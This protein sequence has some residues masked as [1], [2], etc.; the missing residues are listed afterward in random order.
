MFDDKAFGEEID[1]DGLPKYSPDRKNVTAY[2]MFKMGMT[3]RMPDPEETHTPFFRTPSY[4]RE[5]AEKERQDWDVLLDVPA[6]PKMPKLPDTVSG[7]SPVPP[8][9]VE[10]DIPDPQG[11]TRSGSGGASSSGESAFQ[12]IFGK[13][14]DAYVNE[15]FGEKRLADPSFG[16]FPLPDG[17]PAGGSGEAV[18]PE[19]G[20]EAY[21]NQLA[22]GSVSFRD[23]GY[24]FQPDRL[25]A[26]FPVEA[27]GRRHVPGNAV[28]DGARRAVLRG[29][30]LTGR[31]GWHEGLEVSPVP[32]KARGVMQGE[33]GAVRLTG[34]GPVQ[35]GFVKASAGRAGARGSVKELAA[36]SAGK[37]PRKSQ[38]AGSAFRPVFAK[39]N[40]SNPG[41]Q[42]MEIAIVTQEHLP[43]PDG[44]R[45]VS[46]EMSRDMNSELTR[47]NRGYA[48]G[49]N[50]TALSRLEGGS[51]PYANLPIARK[52][53]DQERRERDEALEKG[54]QPPVRKW[55]N[56]SGATIGSGFDLGQTSLDEMRRFGLPESLVQKCAPYVGK[57]R[58]DAEDML[59][60]RPLV[61]TNEEIDIVNRRVMS[62]KAKKSIQDWDSRIAT[63]KGTY[64]NAPYFHEM[65][66][67]QQTIVFSRYY[68]QGSNWLR[69]E[70]NKPMFEAMKQNDWQRVDREMQGRIERSGT[71]WLRNR[72][73]NELDFLNKKFNKP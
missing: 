67:A 2:H 39:D 68:H 34:S 73:K 56:N 53:L 50:F 64:P 63:L 3:D 27:A 13:I 11:T 49:I 37:R 66:S 14:R 35:A 57:K 48:I 30:G 7:P 8:E 70:S 72:F 33:N 19:T 71:T 20:R 21:R 61:L 40:P 10:R 12:T 47:L 59:R 52:E 26:P 60:K 5:K 54:K 17:Q 69:I 43:I 15:F 65:N 16:T 24:P 9:A 4:Y 42:P 18:S 31:T 46:L 25:T 41:F 23:V 55:A 58:L 22:G 29:P 62:D 32:L 36:P 38:H 51:A 1:D 44:R 45:E 6:P 28:P